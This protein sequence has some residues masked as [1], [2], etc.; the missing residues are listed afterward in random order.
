MIFAPFNAANT[1]TAKGGSGH[2]DGNPTT[3]AGDA[4]GQ[5]E[6]P[7]RNKEKGE[8]LAWAQATWLEG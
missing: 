2:R 3:A 1:L 6:S 8:H 7:L 4:T 5:I